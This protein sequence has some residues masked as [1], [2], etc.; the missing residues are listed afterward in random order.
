MLH[1]KE[2]V[3]GFMQKGRVVLLSDFNVRVGRST[4]VDVI[5]MFGEETCN[6]SGNRLI[7]FLNEVELVICNGRK[8]VSEPK[9]TRVRPS[10]QQKSVI[11][12]IVTDV[13][14]MRES[15]DV[16][17]NITDI[18]DLDHFLVR[19]ELGRVTKCC[20]KQKRTIR[21][22]RV[23]RFSDEGVRAKYS[24]ALKVEVESFSESIGEKVREGISGSG[25]V[26]EEWEQ[27]VKKVAKAEVVVVC[28]R[29]VRWWD[30]EIKQ[31]IEHRREAYK[32]ILR[33]RNIIVN[34]VGK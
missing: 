10:L 21:K 9:W 6:A 29:A 12:Y 2:D 25:L 5:G 27:V 11:D 7:S 18:G 20:K 16:Q 22:W 34:C 23:D 14:L 4:D 17:V 33:V 32:K 15:G 3:L 28:G 13:Q 19:L 1:L 30:D 24:E 31:K 8:L 26:V